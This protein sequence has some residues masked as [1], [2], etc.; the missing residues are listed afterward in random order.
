M[1]SR[2]DRSPRAPAPGAARRHRYAALVLLLV[3]AALSACGTGTS[4]SAT[5]TTAPQVMACGTMQTFAYASLPGVE[6][7]LTSLDVY[8][9]PDNGGGCNDRPLVVWVHGGGWAGGD[10]SEF[11]ED[12]IPLF[13][14]AG[15]VLASVN[16]RLT[17]DELAPPSPQYPVHDD[18]VADAVAWLV[19]HAARL[20]ADPS[21]VAVLGHSA[22]GGITAA[23]TTDER[24]LGRHGLRLDSIDC[25]ASMDGEGYDITAGATTAPPEWRQTYT[26]AFGTDPSVWAEASPINHVAA[27]T[28]IPDYFIAA[29]GVDWRLQQHIEFISAL[30]DD[31]R[32]R[33]GARLALARTRRPHHPRRRAGRHHLDP[34]PHVLPRR[35]LGYVNRSSPLWWWLR[36]GD[37]VEAGKEQSGGSHAAP[38]DPC[39]DRKPHRELNRAAR[40]R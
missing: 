2:R 35:L 24:Y 21:E 32:A 22:G 4:R 7:N 16:Y 6:P 1:R 8:T 12:K 30:Q 14:G 9:P 13:N 15:F 17:N 10:K 36:G 3:T 37:E 11:M 25:A 40:T 29:R 19:E 23:I 34:G 38:E 26:N 27:G 39:Q 31:P 5:G 28:G 20:G 18:D 33:H